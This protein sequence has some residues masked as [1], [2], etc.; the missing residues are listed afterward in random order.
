M[1]LNSLAN[2]Y[3][4][5]EFMEQKF[6][7]NLPIII[8]PDYYSCR[9]RL[10]F[11]TLEVGRAIVKAIVVS[12]SLVVKPLSRARSL[13]YPTVPALIPLRV[14]QEQPRLTV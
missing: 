1:A 6:P 12:L 11:Q 14:H 5:F 7:G 10:P 8:S 4:T 9:C 13:A 2:A 3:R